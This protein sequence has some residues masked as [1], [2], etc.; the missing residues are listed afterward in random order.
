MIS[1][2]IFTSYFGT[3]I[4]KTFLCHSEKVVARLACG[5]I[6]T[7]NAS[8]MQIIILDSMFPPAKAKSREQAPECR[9]SET[10]IP[11]ERSRKINT[12]AQE[13]YVRISGII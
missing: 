1:S 9:S 5:G 8:V 13:L 7:T 10:V 3:R 11:L 4:S 2:F 6:I 12:A